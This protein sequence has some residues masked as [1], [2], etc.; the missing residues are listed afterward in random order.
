MVYTVN[1]DTSECWFAAF[2]RNETWT[3]GA[4]KGINRGLVLKLLA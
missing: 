3:L 1:S 2:G 4:T